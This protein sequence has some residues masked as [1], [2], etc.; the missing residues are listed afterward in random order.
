MGSPPLQYALRGQSQIANWGRLCSTNSPLCAWKYD[1]KQLS[2]TTI[3]LG[4]AYV[5]EMRED[6]SAFALSDEVLVEGQDHGKQRQHC[7]AREQDTSVGAHG[8]A[9]PSG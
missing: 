8:S 9:Y 7:D 2:K 3:L 6:C 5:N 1:R 4:S